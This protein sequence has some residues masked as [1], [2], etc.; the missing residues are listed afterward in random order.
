MVFEHVAPDGGTASGFDDAVDEW[1]EMLGVEP[2]F[3]VFG[4]VIHTFGATGAFAELG[5]FIAADVD[6]F[7][8]ENVDG[9]IDEGSA[10]FDKFGARGASL[11]A[12]EGFFAEFA[13]FFGIE[14][15]FEVAEEVDEWDDLQGG[16]FGLQGLDLGG[17]DGTLS[18]G[19]GGAFVGKSVF[20]IEAEGCVSGVLSG[21]GVLV[22]VVEGGG[23][24]AGE[25]DHP[26]SVH[27]C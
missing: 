25:V 17:G 13:T 6:D 9:L 8:F 22:E 15:P 16:K 1:G 24:F 3:F 2:G 23:L 12:G 20:E 7:G 19:P 5:G 27:E 4:L 14:K 11:E 10:E 21:C 18:V 26:D